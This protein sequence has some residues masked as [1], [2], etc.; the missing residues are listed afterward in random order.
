M[1][2]HLW[3]KGQKILLFFCL[4]VVHHL[5]ALERSSELRQVSDTI[6]RGEPS[7]PLIPRTE[8]I[9]CDQD[10]IIQKYKTTFPQLSEQ[11][12]FEKTESPS[13]EGKDSLEHDFT[14]ITEELKDLRIRAPEELKNKR[15]IDAKEIER[16]Q[17]KS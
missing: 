11:R 13:I 2:T 4:E 17:T 5:G 1:T 3:Y 7:T 12:P 9:L 15:K 14:L 10:M 16:K 8:G 6:V